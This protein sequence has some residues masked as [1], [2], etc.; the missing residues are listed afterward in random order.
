MNA[1]GTALAIAAI[2][3][4]FVMIAI[5]GHQERQRQA[6]DALHEKRLLDEL[7]RQPHDEIDE[8]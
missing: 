3:L 8:F 1:G 4:V 2:A 7:K 6:A 5:L